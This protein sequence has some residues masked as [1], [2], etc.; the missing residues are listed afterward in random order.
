MKIKKN[1]EGIKMKKNLERNENEEEEFRK[2]W[3]WRK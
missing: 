2:E 3:K 1:L